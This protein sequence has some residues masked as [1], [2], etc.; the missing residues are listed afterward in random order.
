MN[1][2]DRLALVSLFEGRRLDTILSPEGPLWRCSQVGDLLDYANRGR[3]LVTLVTTE[4]R[5]E[6]RPGEH[7][8]VPQ[9]PTE[10]DGAPESTADGGA[11]KLVLLTPRGLDL[12]LLKTPASVSARLR[13]FVDDQILPQVPRSRPPSDSARGPSIVIILLSLPGL[14]HDEAVPPR[15]S[16]P[17]RPSS[18]VAAMRELFAS[19]SGPPELD[20]DECY[21]MAEIADL[22]GVPEQVVA[23]AV[24]RL[25]F[26]RL[27][28][29]SRSVLLTAPDGRIGLTLGFTMPGVRMVLDALRAT[30]P[31]GAA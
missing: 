19:T 10:A 13:A 1:D 17:R 18:I 27:L 26:R 30:P 12:V 9:A 6:F 8:I 23:R 24:L 11:P 28:G 21:T 7:Y 25:G 15:P 14:G 2:P 3:R 4:W 31:D 16:E 29:C 20:D 5:S 22:A